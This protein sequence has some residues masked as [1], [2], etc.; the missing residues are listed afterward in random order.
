MSGTGPPDSWTLRGRPSIRNSRMSRRES[1]LAG[2]ARTLR[3][4]AARF[5]G[6]LERSPAGFVP[7][8]FRPRSRD[9][10]LSIT[11]VG[12]QPKPTA[13]V[14]VAFA[15]FAAWRFAGCLRLQPRLSTLAAPGNGRR[16]ALPPPDRF[17]SLSCRREAESPDLWG[18]CRRDANR[19]PMLYDEGPCSS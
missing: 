16:Y 9:R 10:L 8:H 14:T 4:R 11:P 6:Q 1:L 13:T 19:R 18:F 5:Q 17:S 12:N 2:L 3:N 15:G 7:A